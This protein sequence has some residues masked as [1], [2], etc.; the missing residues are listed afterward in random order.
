[1][2]TVHNSLKTNHSAKLG[3]PASSD[4][5]SV[6]CGGHPI[7]AAANEALY[8]NLRVN[9]FGQLYLLGKQQRESLPKSHRPLKCGL[10]KITLLKTCVRVP[11]CPS[12]HAHVCIVDNYSASLQSCR[13]TNH[14]VFSITHLFP[15]RLGGSV[16]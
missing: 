15:G 5:V 11:L 4:H 2:I 9:R 7:H 3:E 6:P 1:M 10:E 12:V 8:I 13:N 16:G 14:P